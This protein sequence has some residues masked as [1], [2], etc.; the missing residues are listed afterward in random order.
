MNERIEKIE[1]P[2]N[3]KDPLKLDK[4]SG[5]KGNLM[6]CLFNMN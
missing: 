3:F 4:R 5:W 1:T 6:S 2:H